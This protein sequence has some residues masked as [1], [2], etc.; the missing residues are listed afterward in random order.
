MNYVRS[1]RKTRFAEV[2]RKILAREDA[3]IA[4]EINKVEIHLFF[5]QRK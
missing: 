2:K 4:N 1:R 5:T 3:S